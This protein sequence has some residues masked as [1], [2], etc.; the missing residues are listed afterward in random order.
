MKDKL[1]YFLPIIIV[2]LVA[3]G[4]FYYFKY[5]QKTPVETSDVFSE[6]VLN[7]MGRP[8]KYFY[9][10]GKISLIDTQNKKMAVEIG[11]VADFEGED[12]SS[13]WRGLVRNFIINDKTRISA[14]T[15]P[16]GFDPDDLSSNEVFSGMVKQIN[17]SQLKNNDIVDISIL[18]EEMGKSDDW[19]A[20][21][22]SLG[23]NK[24]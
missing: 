17:F 3:A 14:L 12:F 22:I 16:S 23:N 2:V 13:D 21:S 1:I 24:K 18:K 10:S 11:S 5:Y 9:I 4:G 7:K 20:V 19:S 15:V 6:K 8:E